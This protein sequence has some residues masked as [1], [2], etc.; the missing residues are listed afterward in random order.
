MRVDGFDLPDD[1][2]YMKSHIWV[3]FVGKKAVLGLTS[4]GSSLTKEIVHVDFPDEGEEFSVG[5]PMAS[6]ETIKSVTEITAPFRCRVSR[7]N[8]KLLDDPSQ[9]NRDP[10]SNWI[11]EVNVLGESE[12]ELMD[13]KEAAEYFSKIL[14]AEKE[15]YKGI[16]D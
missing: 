8:E 16:Y 5:E 4:L 9:I 12:G 6:F 2:K 7:I 14:S 10:Y 3:K 1:L 15:R 13:V 11:I